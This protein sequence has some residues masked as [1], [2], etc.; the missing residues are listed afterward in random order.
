MGHPT[1]LGRLSRTYLLALARSAP[2]WELHIYFRNRGQLE[3][4]AGECPSGDGFDLETQVSA[5]K[6]IP[7]FPPINGLNRLVLEELDL[8]RQFGRL[9]LDAYLGCDFT[10]P[11]RSLATRELVILPDM[12]PF[13]QPKTVSW[14]ARLLYRRGI[15]RSVQRRASLLCISQHT[16][17]AL[18][19]TFSNHRC[20]VH[21]IHPALSPR[22]LQLAH[23]SR[24]SDVPLQVHGELHSVNSPGP[25]LLSVGV[26]G[27]RKNTALL[28]NVYRSL[29]LSGEF[30]GS[31]ILA[32]G[33]G[34]CHSAPETR[35]LALETA[36]PSPRNHASP[37]PAVYDLGRVSDRDLSQLYRDA[38]L[39]VN[40][41]TEEGFGYPVLEA[42]A[43]GTPALVTAGSSMTEI[44]TG[45][46]ATTSLNARECTGKLLSAL[47]ALPLLR[48]EASKLPLDYYS[49]DRLGR[50]LKSV[51]ADDAVEVES[52][53]RPD[54]TTN[55]LD[56]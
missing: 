47:G 8:P 54:Q 33:D 52:A 38:D 37:P 20:P 45:G 3:D 29:V 21:V 14:R 2:D 1:G 44:A 24:T 28:V 36:Q 5:G 39:L 10:L 16:R 26:A 50:E 25:Y 42:L 53:A 18:R 11:P 6:I 23:G 7:Y 31:L 4:L 9:E 22:L 51:I 46:I 41:S 49:I 19:S 17:D 35:T 43:H 12:L 13:T 34:Q 15:K 40:L 55:E 32:G 56:G 30:N 27:P 48:Q